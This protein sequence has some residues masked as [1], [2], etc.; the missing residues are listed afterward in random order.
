MGLTQEELA[1]KTGID[2]DKLAKIETGDR[3]VQ[4]TEAMTLANALGMAPEALLREPCVRYRLNRAKPANQ[5]AIRWF[6]RRVES[7]LFARRTVDR[8]HLV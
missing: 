7:S 6:E 3:K 2:R 8:E 5:E 1:Q 4:A